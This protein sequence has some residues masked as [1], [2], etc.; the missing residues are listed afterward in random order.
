[1]ITQTAVILFSLWIIREIV[2]GT[3]VWTKQKKISE[4]VRME[5][6]QRHFAEARNELMGLAMSGAIDMESATFALV[7]YINTMVMRRPDKYPEISAALAATLLSPEPTKENVAIVEESKHWT[8][9]IKNVMNLTADAMNY[10]IL[11][12]SRFW[13]AVYWIE[14]RVDPSATPVGMI[15]KLADHIRESR[16]NK[17]PIISGI[18]KAQEKMLKLCAA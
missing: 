18:Q 11:E 15:R 13:R 9:A 10:I 1:M 12:Y 4:R 14:K 2:V 3:V 6:A 16:A 5:C 7:Y 17:D 8:P